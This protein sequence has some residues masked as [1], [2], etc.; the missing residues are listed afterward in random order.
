MRHGRISEMIRRSAGALLLLGSVGV[1]SDTLSFGNDANCAAPQPACTPACSDD[2]YKQAGERLAQHLQQMGSCAAPCAASCG[3]AAPGCGNCATGCANGSAVGCL[4]DGCEKESCLFGG[5]F[6]HGC[7]D[8]PLG[9]PKLLVDCFT[10]ECGN[11][12]FKE[13]GMTIGGWMQWGYQDGPD[14]AFTGNGPYLNQSGEWNHFNLNQMY[15]YIAKAADGSKGFD[16]GYRV[17]GLYGVDGNEAQSFGNINPGHFDYLNGWGGPGG[18][19]GQF[20]GPH[21][22]TVD[23]E[24]NLYLAEVFNGRVQKFRPKANAERAKLVGQELRY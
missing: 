21:S 18:Q 5:L 23:Q 17:D 6:G 22:M 3:T 19:P 15:L 16:W 24:G 13:K 9:E 20:N 2:F 8:K 7:D 10:D 4:S 1:S 12:C 11:N 14:G